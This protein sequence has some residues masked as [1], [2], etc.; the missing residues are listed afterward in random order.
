MIYDI[1]EFMLESAI[2]GIFF[3]IIIAILIY[4]YMMV[5]VYKDAK[6][7]NMDAI[8]YLVL[9]FFF[10]CCGLIIYHMARADHPVGGQTSPSVLQGPR[11]DTTHQTQPQFGQTQYGQPQYGQPPH[12]Q[13]QVPPSPQPQKISHNT[14]FCKY[15]GGEMPNDARFCSIC[16]ANEFN[17]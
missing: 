6:K 16:G 9:V 3:V 17:N 10:S 8:L 14:K 11:M 1:I 12:G 5:W 4:I 2:L 7:R 15:C 13:T